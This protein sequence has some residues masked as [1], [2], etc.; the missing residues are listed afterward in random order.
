MIYSCKG[1]V[2]ITT[3]FNEPARD[4]IDKVAKNVDISR[5]EVLRRLLELYYQSEEGM[6]ECPSCAQAIRLQVDN[7]DLTSDE[8]DEIPTT[9][10]IMGTG[11]VEPKHNTSLKGPDADGALLDFQVR[12]SELESIT[13]T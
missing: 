10:G 7:V 8:P 1:K 4:F 11:D 12:V 13:E 5:S 3:K 9:K 6:L 2:P